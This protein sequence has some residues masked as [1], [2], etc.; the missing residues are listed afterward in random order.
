LVV[1]AAASLAI[2]VAGA[3]HGP[4]ADWPRAANWIGEHAAE[5]ETV[6]VVPPRARAA[7]LRYA[8]GTR[9]HAAG[10]GEGV[11]VVLRTPT[12]EAI[13]TA[14]TVVATPR[15][16]LLEEHSFG[17]DLVVEHWVRP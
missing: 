1:A 2:G 12:D 15:Y 5:R 13:A 4:A 7:Y 17:N 10:R 8:D 16:A 6:V 9:L 14:R 3:A 11:W